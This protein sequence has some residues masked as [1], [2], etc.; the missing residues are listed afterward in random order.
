MANQT[1]YKESYCAH[2]LLSQDEVY[3]SIGESKG[4]SLVYES[5]T[6]LTGGRAS[7]K[8]TSQR[9]LSERTGDLYMC[10]T[11]IETRV[12]VPNPDDS[13]PLINI[14][15]QEQSKPAMRLVSEMMIY[16]VMRHL[17]DS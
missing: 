7:T 8:K 15:L 4:F 17:A 13:E 11:M 3:F 5:S 14:Y 6:Y 2:V 10:C 9:G 12:K 16:G 1:L